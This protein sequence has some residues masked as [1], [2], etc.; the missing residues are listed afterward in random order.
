MLVEYCG[1]I[2][3]GTNAV[4]CKQVAQ[5]LEC[6][7][8]YKILRIVSNKLNGEYNNYISSENIGKIDRKFFFIYR[9]IEGSIFIIFKEEFEQ[10]LKEKKIPIIIV[11][12]TEAELINKIMLCNYK[13]M[14]FYIYNEQM[15]NVGRAD[16]EI[17]RNS[18]ERNRIIKM[19]SY[20]LNNKN[21]IDTVMLIDKAWELRETG[22][23][24]SREYIEKLVKCDLLIK[25][26]KNTS[27]S[28]SSY[29]LSL[30]DEYYYAGKIGEL[31]DK[32]PFL[33]IEPYDYVIA[34]CY[35]K[36]NMPRD[37]SGKFDVS[38][39]LFCEGMILSN[40]TQVDPGFRGK[41]FC[42]LFNTSNKVVYLKRHTH[43]VT[44]DFNKLVEP[45]TPYAGKYADED[46]IVPYLPTN[47]MQGAI[48]E[49]KKEI[50]NLKI[51]NQKMQSIY[52][53]VLALFLA[54]VSIIFTLR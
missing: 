2:I 28:N 48:N 4:E 50:E 35:E 10:I 18:N 44:M 23:G 43:F 21:F 20:G 41:L 16:E 27:V 52:L 13:F 3:S 22:G 42:L 36:I 46:S 34:S 11:D 6:N 29:D 24:L 12:K 26:G 17:K 15:E 51:E 8:N 14:S 37:V 32:N 1:I 38:V 53:S 54:I 45:T 47:V 31:S 40:S 30:G 49:L 9:E 19:F 33:A 25:D 39:N 5:K 7:Y